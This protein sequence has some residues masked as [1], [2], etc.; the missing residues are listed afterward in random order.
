MQTNNVDSDLPREPK[1]QLDFLILV[2]FI[3]WFDV[4]FLCGI[5]GLPVGL[6][7]WKQRGHDIV[8]PLLVAILLYQAWLCILAFRTMHF[9]IKC[10]GS[11]KNTTYDAARLAASYLSGG[12]T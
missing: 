6:I 12:K 3:R 2:G 4:P 5:F 11:V 8:L 9:V 7:L 10:I 1:N